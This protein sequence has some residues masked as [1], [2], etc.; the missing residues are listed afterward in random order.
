MLSLL[1]LMSDRQNI[2]S[3]FKTGDLTFQDD[4]ERAFSST[5]KTLMT[6]G[7]LYHSP[8]LFPTTLGSVTNLVENLK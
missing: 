1:I 4:L 7:R 3:K 5:S 2:H 8:C 6:I